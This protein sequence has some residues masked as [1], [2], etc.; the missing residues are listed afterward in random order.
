MLS[1]R[2]GRRLRALNMGTFKEYYTFL[3]ETL[4]KNDEMI[5]MLDVVTTNTTHFFRESNHFRYL[6]D[7]ALPQLT[8]SSDTIK[9][10]SAGCS[11]GEEPYTLTMVLS[12]YFA[13][14]AGDFSILAS[15]IST[16]VL[17]K[18]KMAV[19]SDEDVEGISPVYRNKYLMRGKGDQ[20]GNWRIIPE[21]R[22]KVQFH[23][24]NFMDDNYGIDDQFDIIFCRNVIIYFDW[25]TKARLIN[26]FYDHLA[27][28]GYLFIGHS[29]TLNGMN[30][31]FK[32]VAPTVYRKPDD[33]YMNV[34]RLAA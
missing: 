22:K 21:L 6:T 27:P 31:N 20:A 3:T 17:K 8:S 11:S 33:Y 14:N 19:Y 4:G 12:D 1:A 9:I 13:K 5:H 7:E 29:E 10:W 28:G 32:A 16:N 25:D 2:L 23:R 34:R 15:D 30:E 24:L 18:A 26:R